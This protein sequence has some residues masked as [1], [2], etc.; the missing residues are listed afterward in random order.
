[1]LSLQ[2]EDFK[3]KKMTDS[4]KKWNE[5]K[6]GL[7]QTCNFFQEFKNYSV[8]FIEVMTQNMFQPSDCQEQLK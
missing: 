3:W 1:M 6:A 7:K 5:L 8:T 4:T 2:S